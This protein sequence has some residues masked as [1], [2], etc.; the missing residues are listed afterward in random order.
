[1]V[2][3]VGVLCK[4]CGDSIEIHDE[5]IP[6]IDGTKVARLYQAFWQ[7][8]SHRLANPGGT[9]NMVRRVWQASLQCANPDCAQ[10]HEYQAADLRLL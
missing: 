2:Q 7:A 5:Y 4:S 10:L 9:G 1:M 6:G 3:K 8:R